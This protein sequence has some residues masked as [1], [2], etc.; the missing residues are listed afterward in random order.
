MRL[1]LLNVAVFSVPDLGA[2]G[3]LVYAYVSYLVFG[4][5][6]SLTNIPYGSLAT[7]STQDPVERSKLATFRV[8]GSNLAILALA[9]IGTGLYL[10]TFR[11]SRENVQH[12]TPTPT[13]RETFANA[14]RK[15]GVARALRLQRRR[16]RRLVLAADGHHL[17]RA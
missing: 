4:L 6:Y 15:Q 10:F 17:L 14:R 12:G 2:T 9:V 1:L 3:T 11:T 8:F 5:A 13:L 7:S 16:P